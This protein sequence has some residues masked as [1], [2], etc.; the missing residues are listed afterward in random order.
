[1]AKITRPVLK[2]LETLYRFIDGQ[3]GAPSDVELGLGVT[4][5]HDLSRM[6][7]IGAANVV[8]NSAGY[9]L[10]SMRNVHTVTGALTLNLNFVTPGSVGEGYTFDERTQWIWIIDD[11]GISNDA[12]DFQE[13]VLSIN[14]ITNDFFIGPSEGVPAS[15]LNMIARYTGAIGSGPLV[16][17]LME[18]QYPKLILSPQDGIRY[19]TLADSAGTVT[20]THNIL[21]WIGIRNTFPPGMY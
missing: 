14:P 16:R 13:A 11:W 3:D 8:R 20:I 5:V 15:V 1:M 10:A 18:T 9:W 12:T 7:E 19:L 4:P 17:N 6:A 2:T 21:L